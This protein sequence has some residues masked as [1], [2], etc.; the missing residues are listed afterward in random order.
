V[1]RY[2]P[3]T[4]LALDPAHHRVAVE[5]GVAVRLVLLP[6]GAP[7]SLGDLTPDPELTGAAGVAAD[8]AGHLYVA[9][10]AGH[11]V[12]RRDACSGEMRAL[13]ELSGPGRGPEQVATPRGVAAGGGRLFVADSG[14]HRVHVLD[15]RTLRRLAVWGSATGTPPAPSA[16]PG[17]LDDPWDLAVDASG[18]LY[19][20]DHGNRR[21]QRFRPDGEVDTAFAAALAADGGPREPT[22]VTVGRVDGDERVVVLDANPPRLLVYE[23]DGRLDTAATVRW[24]GVTV[25][26][27][28]GVAFVDGR[29]YV[30][31]ADAG[32]V[33]VHDAEGRLVGRADHAGPVAGLAVDVGVGLVVHPGAGPGLVR[34]ALDAGRAADGWL[35]VGP[36]TAG[37]GPRWHRV[38]LVADPPA[39]GAHV[40]LLTCTTPEDGSPPP[41]ATVTPSGSTDTPTPAGEWRPVAR[42]V[43]DALVLN[44]PGPALW[45]AAVLR[46]DG[47]VTPALRGLRVEHDHE[48]WLEHLPALY[49]RDADTAR[50]L[51][52]ALSLFE[53]LLEGEREALAGLP[54]LFDPAT[55]PDAGPAPTWLDWLAGWVAVT[56]DEGWP[57]S[58]RRRIVA[59]AIELHAIRGTAEGLR[60]AIAAATGA[61]ARVEEPGQL[62]AP[63]SLGHVSTLGFTTVLAGSEAQGAVLGTTAA[64]GGSHLIAGHE[65]GAPLF[66]DVAHRVCVQ[67][68]AAE[69]CEPGARD[70]VER[71]V[72]AEVPAHVVAHVCALEPRLTVGFQARVGVDAILG[73]RPELALGAR[74]PLGVDTVLAAA[75]ALAG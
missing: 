15:L 25:A 31:D 4:G 20:V 21:V 41:L 23:V 18:H 8:R 56:L 61:R 44:A 71:L 13:A 43:P 40:Q 46:G 62:A 36:L 26:R 5:D 55:A 49:R 2:V 37:G 6:P 48:T 52:R 73:R 66:D 50:F 27:P 17:R 42:D 74:R 45:V 34:L 53:T 3:F 67:V 58:R 14:N 59:E 29:L 12:L 7:E 72:R 22:H 75:P 24:A 57:E 28:G 64:A 39:G 9:D 11:C 51:G 47:R 69:L 32:A 10:P 1:R 33:L 16:T 70:R 63:W 35:V 54:R 65:H 30:G 19:V 68:H 38:T 60:R